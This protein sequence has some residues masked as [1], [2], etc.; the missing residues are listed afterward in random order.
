[1]F[2]LLRTTPAFLV[3][4]AINA[5]YHLLQVCHNTLILIHNYS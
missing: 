3:I 4:I 5:L 1:M 2:I